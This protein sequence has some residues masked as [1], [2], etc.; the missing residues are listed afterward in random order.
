MHDQTI[1]NGSDRTPFELARKM[2]RPHPAATCLLASTKRGMIGES[3]NYGAA[4]QR[5]FFDMICPP[6]RTKRGMAGGIFRHRRLF[7]TT[8][9]DSVAFL[10]EMLQRTKSLKPRA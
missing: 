9:T 2:K 10:Q 5:R 4:Q 3:R 7:A 6:L 1:H 8:G